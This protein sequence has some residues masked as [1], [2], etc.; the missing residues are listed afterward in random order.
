MGLCSTFSSRN[1]GANR[2]P[3]W[4][5][6]EVVRVDLEGCRVL[7]P[8]LADGLERGSP[9]QPLEVLGEVVGRDEGAD[10]GVQGLR[11]GVMEQLEVASLAVRFI[12]CAW[13][14]VQR[15]V[16]RSSRGWL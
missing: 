2:P 10:V 7:C 14:F 16:G 5:R 13:P 6:D 3:G 9:S 15:L 8:G 1:G 12:T 11:V 4:S